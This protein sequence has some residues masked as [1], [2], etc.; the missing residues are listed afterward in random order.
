MNFALA[1]IVLRYLSAAL[2]TAGYLSPELADQIG[3]DPDL[4][5]LVGSALA[6]IT[7]AAYAHAKKT[8]GKT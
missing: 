6:F 5:M 1:R 7:E 2:V 4:V 3:T 8:G